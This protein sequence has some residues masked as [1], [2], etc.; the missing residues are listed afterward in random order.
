MHHGQLM[1][2]LIHAFDQNDHLLPLLLL[3]SPCRVDATNRKTA[4]PCRCR[5]MLSLLD[6]SHLL[7][8]QFVIAP[9]PWQ[10]YPAVIAVQE[11]SSA[12]SLW[13]LYERIDNHNHQRQQSPSSTRFLQVPEIASHPHLPHNK[14][15]AGHTKEVDRGKMWIKIYHKHLPKQVTPMSP[16]IMTLLRQYQSHQRI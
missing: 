1:P 12:A 4:P 10:V 13:R 2:T 3:L 7:C 14:T 5:S 6:C 16:K 15:H 11:K 8:A 9:V